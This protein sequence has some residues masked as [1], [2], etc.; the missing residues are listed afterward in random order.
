MVGR[1]QNTN[2]A[3]VFTKIYTRF[4][5]STRPL[6]FLQSVL[7]LQLLEKYKSFQ[8]T[9]GAVNEQRWKYYEDQAE[10]YGGKRHCACARYYFTEL[11]AFVVGGAHPQTNF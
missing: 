8:E 6:N 11:H 1:G 10:R 3:R 4:A 5:R 9:R 7:N 2:S